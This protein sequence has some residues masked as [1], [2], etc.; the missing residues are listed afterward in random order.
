MSQVK[1]VT[2]HHKRGHQILREKSIAPIWNG[3]PGTFNMLGIAV[4]TGGPG[5][6]VQLLGALGPDFPLPIL[7]VQ[8]MTA[9]FIGAFASWLGVACPCPVIVVKDGFVPVAGSV[10]IA[11]AE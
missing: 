9:S 2:Q 11:T 7:L 3:E 6:L 4:S 8:H 5:A 10:H 1:L